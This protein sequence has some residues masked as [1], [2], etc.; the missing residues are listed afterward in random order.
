MSL[1]KIVAW[2]ITMTAEVTCVNDDAEKALGMA[3]VA[4]GT[5]EADISWG[6]EKIVA[7]V[8]TPDVAPPATP[9]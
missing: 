3:K 8:Y 5:G 6:T 4:I 7:Q 1:Q 9:T 2:K